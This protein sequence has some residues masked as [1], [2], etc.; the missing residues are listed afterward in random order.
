MTPPTHLQDS[1][2]EDVRGNGIEKRKYTGAGRYLT[3]GVITPPC[4]YFRKFRT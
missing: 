3:G 4:D 1:D 2:M